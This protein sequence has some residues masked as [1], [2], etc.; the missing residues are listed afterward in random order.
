MS[1]KRLN[2]IH[3]CS[4]LDEHDAEGMSQRV[5]GNFFVYSGKPSLF[6]YLPLEVVFHNR[7]F[8]FLGLSGISGY[9]F[10]VFAPALSCE[11]FVL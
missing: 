11:R 9:L 10:E 6:F 4:T 7:E 8:E 5:R 3:E 2:S 1:Q